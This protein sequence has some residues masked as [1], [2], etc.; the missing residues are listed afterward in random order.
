MKTRILAIGDVVGKPGRT[1]IAQRL[2]DYCRKELVDCVIANGENLAGGSGLLPS[3]ADELF[4]AGV[5]VITGGDHVWGKKEIIPYI[6]RTPRLIRP[7]NYPESQPGKGFAIVETPSGVKVGVIHVQGRVFMNVPCDCPFQTAERLVKEI[8]LKT[9][10]IAIDMHCEAT[11]EKV[12]MG[13]W[14]DGKASFVFGTHTHIQTADERILPQGTAYITDCGMTG[15]YDSVI[16][17]RTDR[18]LHRFTTG[19]P[20]HFEVATG[21]VRLSGALATIDS[22]SGLA[23]EIKRVVILEDGT[24][25]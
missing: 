16:G 8:K 17:R 21:D 24:V 19:M 7:A 20:A 9:N 11:S 14:M 12:G 10:V 23:T 4:R 1:I 3:E 13:W 5:H 22:G 25:K 2:A 18:V 6:D 15:P